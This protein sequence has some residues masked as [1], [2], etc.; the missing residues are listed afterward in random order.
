MSLITR[1]D[2][3]STNNSAVHIVD[4]ETGYTLATIESKSGKCELGI[5]TAPHLHIEKPNGFTTKKED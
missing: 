3:R 1:I 4:T 5:R 2:S